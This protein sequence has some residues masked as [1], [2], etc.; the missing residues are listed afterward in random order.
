MS[1]YVADIRDVS[2]W[3]SVKGAR[4]AG[5]MQRHPYWSAFIMLTVGKAVLRYVW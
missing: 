5:W 3:A 1:E 4:I 2:A